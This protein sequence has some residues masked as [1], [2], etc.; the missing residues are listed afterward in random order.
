MTT[1]KIQ[2]GYE[3]YVSLS[4]VD[5]V[6]QN[7][8][9]YLMRVIFST[10]PPA[11]DD[12]NYHPFVATDFIYK[13]NGSPTGKVY[14]KM[15]QPDRTGIVLVSEGVSVGTTEDPTLGITSST[16]TLT[17][18]LRDYPERLLSELKLLRVITEETFQ[19]SLTEEDIK[20]V[21]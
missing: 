12:E 17:N 6:I 2:V 9:S 20:D 16:N 7:T 11:A 4:E 15:D 1:K 18:T 10:F 19:T 14:A 3:G 13:K 5:C 8:S 21:R